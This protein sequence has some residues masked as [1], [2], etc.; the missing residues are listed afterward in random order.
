M[1][2]LVH[3]T[4]LIPPLTGI[5]HYTHQLLTHLVSDSRVHDIKA[6]MPLKH[7]SRQDLQQ[8][9][10]ALSQ[11]LEP[12]SGIAGK[13]KHSSP[14]Y[15]SVLRRVASFIPGQRRLRQ[16]VQ[17][18]LSSKFMERCSHYVYWEPNYILQP[19]D[20]AAI[21]TVHDL[22]H[23]RYPEHHPQERV[24]W[25]GD[26]LADSLDRSAAVIAVSNFSKKE[27]NDVF[28][29]DPTLIKVISPAVSDTFRQTRTAQELHQLR[30]RYRLPSEYILSV[31]TL[32][33]RKNIAGLISAFG[34]LSS[35]LRQ[36]FPL[37]LV[38]DSGW[39]NEKT[40]AMLQPYLRRG[41]IIQLGYVPQN[42]LPKLYAAASLFAYVSFYEG[43]G[44]PIAEAMASGVA[45]V[46]SDRASMPEVAAGCAV[47]VNPDD[48]ES[49][50][51][52]LLQILED[53]NDR[54][55]RASIGKKKSVT[56]TWQRSADQLVELFSSLEETP[57]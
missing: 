21:A 6:F 2:V 15:H 51:A 38:G 8:L 50:A 33:P 25:L 18:R 52:G 43:Y 35:E 28:N 3:T 1:N 26:R 16:F 27:I 55:R 37:V 46:A 39:H 34:L 47:L 14:G 19:F 45:V 42:D 49:I 5:G 7:Y 24:R 22:S 17:Q 44:M 31:G 11:P 57:A 41:E 9:L 32:E 20:G 12:K 29:I 13:I 53:S 23:I 10:I 48:I 56:Y 4:S 36:K 54:N 40:T 30:Q